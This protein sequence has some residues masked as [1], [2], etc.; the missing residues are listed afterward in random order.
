MDVKG[1]NHI[2]G[3]IFATMLYSIH[4]SESSVNNYSGSYQLIF[5]LAAPKIFLTQTAVGRNFS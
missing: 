3:N 1:V 2:L 4:E 5:T